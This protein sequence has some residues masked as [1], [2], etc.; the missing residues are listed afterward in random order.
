MINIHLY[1][2]QFLNESRILREARTLAKLELFDRIDLIGAG[3]AGLASEEKLDR[4]IRIRRIGS[5]RDDANLAGKVG[6]A[7]RWSRSIYREYRKVPLACVNCHSIATLPL[8]WALKRATGARLVYDAHELETETS[9]LRG[10]RKAGTKVIERLLIG[11]VDYSI[12]VGSTIDEWYRKQYGLENTA[13]VYNSPMFADVVP[14]NHFRQVFKIAADLPIFLYQGVV[15]EAR[16]VPKLVAA[17]SA[18]AGR[19]TLVVMGYGELAPW[20]QEQAQR[21]CNIFY[22]PAV[23]PDQLLCYTAAA[24]Y[25]LSVIESTSLSYEYCMPNKLFEY[26]MARKPVLVSRNREQREFVERYGVGVVA[27]ANTPEAI[28][29]GAVSLMAIH[30]SAILAAIDRV[31]RDFSWEQQESVLRSVYLDALGFRPRHEAAA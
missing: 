13:V 11:Y 15:S 7:V 20:M 4:V 16:G 6:A 27:A 17:F 30:P 14:S 1:P 19:A 5:R 10:V 2:S 25:G 23:P 28:R 3:G 26:L 21:Y 29:E 24:D 12:F 22:H 8:G 9:G 31:R 18:L